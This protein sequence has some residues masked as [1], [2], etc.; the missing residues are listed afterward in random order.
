MN[1]AILKSKLR[2]LAIKEQKPYD[3]IQIHWNPEKA[4]WC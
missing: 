3:Y 1:P 4:E 2:N